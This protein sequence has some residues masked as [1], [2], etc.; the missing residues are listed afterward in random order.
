MIFSVIVFI[1][2]FSV[3]YTNQVDLSTAKISDQSDD[4]PVENFN[5]GDKAEAN[6]KSEQTA[7]VRDEINS[8]DPQ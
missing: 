7:H 1:Q 4:E 6:A 5:P 8:C 3:I 2:S